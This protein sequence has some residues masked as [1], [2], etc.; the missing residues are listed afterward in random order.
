MKHGLCRAVAWLVVALITLNVLTAAGPTIVRLAHAL[1]PLVVAVG[2][3]AALL[4]IV[5][6]VTS[7][8]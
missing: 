5:W 8:Y 1:A 2:L 6:H 3:I 7:R 4:R